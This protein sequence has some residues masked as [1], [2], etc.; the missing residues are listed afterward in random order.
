MTPAPPSRTSILQKR[1]FWSYLDHQV[2]GSTLYNRA[3]VIFSKTPIEMNTAAPLLGE[4]TREVLTG[5]LDYSEAQV[6]QMTEEKI[7]I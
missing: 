4:H 5:M 3:P 1:E 6:D 7:L 2:V